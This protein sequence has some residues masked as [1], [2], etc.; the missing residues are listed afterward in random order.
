[1]PHLDLSDDE[2]AAHATPLTRTI[3]DDRY[4][5]SLWVRTLN[6]IPPNLRPE[7]VPEPLPRPKVY[8][9]PKGT[10][11]RRRRG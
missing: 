5:L 6:D 11:A 3:A 9:S 1:M 10:A 8:A 2:A 4:L 7:P